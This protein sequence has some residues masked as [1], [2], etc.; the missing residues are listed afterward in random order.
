MASLLGK[1][2]KDLPASAESA[3]VE[4]IFEVTTKPADKVTIVVDLQS[5]DSYL[6]GEREG[7]IFF[8]V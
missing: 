8:S 1:S 5:D 4:L 6:A 2:P 3:D 7:C